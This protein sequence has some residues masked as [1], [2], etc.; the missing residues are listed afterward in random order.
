[1]ML[2]RERGKPGNARYEKE[3]TML[4]QIEEGDETRYEE[5]GD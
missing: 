2:D 5:G 1:M 4:Q 3:G